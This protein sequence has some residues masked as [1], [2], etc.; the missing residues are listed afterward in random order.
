MTRSQPLPRSPR[1]KSGRGDFYF[2]VYTAFLEHFIVETLLTCSR[3][4]EGMSVDILVDM[5]DFSDVSTSEGTVRM[6]EEVFATDSFQEYAKNRG[7][8]NIVSLCDKAMIHYDGRGRIEIHESMSDSNPEFDGFYH[9]WQG[10]VKNSLDRGLANPE[11]IRDRL[12]SYLGRR[13]T[14]PLVPEET[15]FERCFSWLM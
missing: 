8:G 10:Y 9:D 14:A 3:F 6:L 13:E 12:L 2:S 7:R 5:V 11:T 15:L 4:Q 1:F